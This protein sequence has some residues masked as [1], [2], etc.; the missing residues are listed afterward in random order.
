MY[1]IFKLLQLTTL[2]YN[3]TERK[4]EVSYNKFVFTSY[5]AALSV[6]RSIVSNFIEDETI[7]EKG[8]KNHYSSSLISLHAL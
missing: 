4:A 6:L 3:N 7:K 1:F 5:I 8:L 2:L